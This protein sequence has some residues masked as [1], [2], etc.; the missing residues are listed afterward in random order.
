M[1]VSGWRRRGKWRRC[2]WRA[3]EGDPGPVVAHAGTEI[4]VAGGLLDVAEGNAGVE[5]SGDERVTKRVGSHTLGYP[6]PSGDAAHDPPGGVAIDPSAVGSDEDRPIAALADRQID[7]PGGAGRERHG[8]DLASPWRC[9][10]TRWNIA[11]NLATASCSS[12]LNRSS[13]VASTVLVEMGTSIVEPPSVM[14]RLQ[15]PGPVKQPQQP[16]DAANRMSGRRDRSR[17]GITCGSQD[18]PPSTRETFA[19]ARPTVTDRRLCRWIC[20]LR[21]RRLSSHW[22]RRRQA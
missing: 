20:L 1:G 11:R 18:Q 19:S 9:Y 17:A 12:G 7:G 14:P 13:R 5:G 16:S 6:G 22:S 8:H 4:G 2:R 21:A 15:E 3:V 10:R